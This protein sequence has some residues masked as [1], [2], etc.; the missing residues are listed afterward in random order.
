MAPTRRKDTFDCTMTDQRTQD[1]F[2]HILSH[3]HTG[4]CVTAERCMRTFEHSWQHGDIPFSLRLF[5]H[6]C[7]SLHLSTNE[8]SRKGC[9]AEVALGGTFDPAYCFLSQKKTQQRNTS[10]EHKIYEPLILFRAPSL[11]SANYLKIFHSSENAFDL[12][13]MNRNLSG[14]YFGKHDNICSLN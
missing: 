9:E 12:G 8:Q 3:T 11:F 14:Q 5:P 1:F 6:L 4:N 10:R 2:T 7:D 13:L